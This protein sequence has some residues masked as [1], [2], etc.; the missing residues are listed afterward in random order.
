MGLLKL[1]NSVLRQKGETIPEVTEEVNDRM[2]QLVRLLAVHNGA[3]MA[4]TQ[5]GWNARAFV[6]HGNYI[7]SQPPPLLISFYK[8]AGV[9]GAGFINPEVIG[10]WDFK[11][12]EESCLS[13]PGR[14]FI[15]KRPHGVQLRLQDSKGRWMKTRIEG[16]A[17]RVILHEMDHLNGVLVCDI[18]DE[19]K[20]EAV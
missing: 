18:G 10:A 7:S 2:R 6:V 5:V 3:G 9:Y 4:A 14:K 11:T 19:V 1:P 8:A 20:K 17:A 15:V 12:L 16:T 13:V